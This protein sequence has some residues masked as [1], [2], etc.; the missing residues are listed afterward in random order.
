MKGVAVPYII[1]IL[2]GVAVIG[3]IGY[4]L[5]VA[6]GRIPEAECKAAQEAWC[7]QWGSPYTS[8]QPAKPASYPEGCDLVTDEICKSL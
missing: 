1:A 7:D 3:L 6:G 4:W 2:L 8:T 5:F